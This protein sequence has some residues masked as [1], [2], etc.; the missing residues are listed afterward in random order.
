M[1]KMAI[2]VSLSLATAA[3]VIALFLTR[4]YGAEPLISIGSAGVTFIGTYNLAQNILEKLGYLWPSGARAP[5]LVGGRPRPALAFGRGR[6]EARRRSFDLPV[7]PF[8]YGQSI[9]GPEGVRLC[10]GVRRG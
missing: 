4:H 5:S 9:R 8:L 7:V 2:L 3:A 6:R 1:K 10:G